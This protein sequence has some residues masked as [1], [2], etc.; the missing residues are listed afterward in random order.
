MSSVPVT[1][2]SSADRTGRRP[3]SSTTPG[4]RRSAPAG[5]SSTHSSGRPT[6]RAAPARPRHLR[7]FASRRLGERNVLGA[8]LDQAAQDL[9]LVHV[10]H[11]SGQEHVPTSYVL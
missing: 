7:A 3:T 2:P 11:Q 9:L 5:C 8:V 6:A 4:T 10:R 1:T